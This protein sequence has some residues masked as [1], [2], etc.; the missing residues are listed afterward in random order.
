MAIAGSAVPFPNPQG[1]DP[2]R[3]RMWD[4]TSDRRPDHEPGDLVVGIAPPVGSTLSKL[5][6]VGWK[7]DGP[8]WLPGFDLR[9]E[10]DLPAN[11]STDQQP[12]LGLRGAVGAIRFSDRAR[13]HWKWERGA[14]AF[15]QL[16]NSYVDWKENAAGRPCTFGDLLKV[17]FDGARPNDRP[18]RNRGPG[19]SVQMSR[20]RI[21]H[22][23]GYVS[24]TVDPKQNGHSDGTQCMGGVDDL[25][26]GDCYVQT[27]G[28]QFF[29]LGR[30]AS[31][32][33]YNSDTLWRLTR[34]TL[35]HTPPWNPALK[36]H[37]RNTHP[38]LVEGYE[39][40]PKGLER[41][42]WPRGLYLAT[43]FTDCNIR[44][45]WAKTDQ[46]NI[47]QY[48]GPQAGVL[49]IGPDGLFRFDPRARGRHQRPMWAGTLR[50]FEP[51]ETL[52]TLCPPANVGP[53]HRVTSPEEALAAMIG[54]L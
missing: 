2:K 36:P 33:G 31:V 40:E 42:S 51:G 29:F 28:G 8:V 19:V 3:I 14:S 49:G 54:T 35:D 39:G 16:A 46:K 32:C 18:G 11:Y 47:R 52:P 44:G 4:T 5:P 48:L 17:Q 13:A 1:V 27:V 37:V 45:P 15:V 26:A 53:A 38:R 20:V 21:I 41:T 9:P 25:Q 22:G 6:C 34:F 43:Q 24:D 12:V 23:S 7:F 30:E 10:G 50:Y